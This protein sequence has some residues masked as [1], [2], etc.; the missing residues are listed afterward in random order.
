MI[1]DLLRWIGHHTP[2]I[3]Y[4]RAIPN[5]IL[6]PLHK[7]LGLMGGVVDILGFSMRLN[8]QE[9]VDADLYFAPHLYDRDEIHYLLQK[10]SKQGVFIDAGANI[11]FWSLLFAEKFPQAKIYSIEAN[12]STFDILREN[13]EINKFLNIH[14]I[15]I[16]V[17]DKFGEFP[18]YCNDTGNRG[19]DSFASVAS[20][21]NRNIMVATKPLTSIFEEADIKKIDIMKMDIEGFEEIVL[22]SFFSEAPKTLWPRFICAEIIHVPQVMNLLHSVGY[23]LML[24]AREN[25][26]YG[27]EM[28]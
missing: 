11:G 9:C 10:F 13:I 2:N 26:V 7:K 19:G 16:G 4:V 3:R 27:L 8:P 20:D 18:L 5:M 1:A 28:E 22:S 14:A 21:R 6:K 17:S 12:P 25:C 23:H 15:N 24:T